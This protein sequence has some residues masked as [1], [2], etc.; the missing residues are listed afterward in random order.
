MKT[1]TECWQALLDGKTLVRSTGWQVKLVDGGQVDETGKYQNYS[2]G[3]YKEWSIKPETKTI[4][5]EQLS[6]AY[7]Q[8]KVGDLLVEIMWSKL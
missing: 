8:T 2:F 6:E 3:C 1:Q 5:K 7:R 4:T